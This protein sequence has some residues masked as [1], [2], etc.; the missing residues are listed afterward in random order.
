MIKKIAI[1][2]GVLVALFVIVG[3]IAPKEMKIERT[4]TINKPKDDVFAYLVLLKNQDQW[5]PWSKKDPAMTKSYKGED[6]TVGF[7]GS[8]SG[9]KEVGVGEQEIKKIVPG[10]RI[11]YELRFKK[12]M[13]NT[14]VSYLTTEAIGD[15]QTKVT[16]GFEGEHKFPC[17]VICVAMNMK[18]KM[19]SALDEGLASLKTILEKQTPEAAAPAGDEL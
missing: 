17:N 1:G 2:L 12:P 11:E 10:E 4:I 16:W 8:W 9:N 3:L 15:K 13:E 7:V 6:G 5:S 14:S 19:V 18:A